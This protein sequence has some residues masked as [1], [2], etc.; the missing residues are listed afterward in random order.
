MRRKVRSRQVAR[1]KRVTI[2]RVVE[3]EE[4]PD[5]EASDEYLLDVL[6]DPYEQVG[7]DPADVAYF[8][9]IEATR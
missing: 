6:S 5:G 4:P 3:V 8:D 2:A 7:L 1:P 9:M